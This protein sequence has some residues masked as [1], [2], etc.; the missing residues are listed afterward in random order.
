MTESSPTS[1]PPSL[2]AILPNGEAVRPERV[3]EVTIET[4]ALLY[5]CEIERFDVVVHLVGGTARTVG[6]RLLRPAAERLASDT[7]EA[8]NGACRR[9]PL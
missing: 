7:A 5:D 9:F 8:I 2:L 4:A 6:R 1:S 3:L